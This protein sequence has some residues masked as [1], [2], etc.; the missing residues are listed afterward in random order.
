MV[1]AIFQIFGR[2]YRVKEGDVLFV[3]VPN[4]ESFA[5]KKQGKIFAEAKL[6]EDESNI[7]VGSDATK[8]KVELEVLGFLRSKKINTKKFERRKRYRKFITTRRSF[9][10]F[11]VDKI[12]KS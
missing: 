11:K 7:L 6:V 12:A 9:V 2:E 8:Y 3:E 10:K 4:A 5:D 1:V